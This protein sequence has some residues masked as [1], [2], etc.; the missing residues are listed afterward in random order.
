MAWLSFVSH[1]AK[2]IEQSLLFG[3]YKMSDF[4]FAEASLIISNNELH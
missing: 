3:I 2:K 1:V 4:V